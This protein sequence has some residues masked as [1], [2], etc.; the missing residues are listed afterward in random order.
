MDGNVNI[1]LNYSI[2]LSSAPPQIQVGYPPVCSII[3]VYYS[4]PGV[5]LYP[6]YLGV[7]KKI[8]Y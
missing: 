7:V 3:F 1:C 4:F 5:S 6:L 2:I 8:D